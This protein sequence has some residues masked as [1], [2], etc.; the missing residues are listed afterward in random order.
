MLSSRSIFGLLL[1]CILI[2]LC[3]Y[4]LTLFKGDLYDIICKEFSQS[5]SDSG[6][7]RCSCPMSGDGE[8]SD[9]LIM[10]QVDVVRQRVNTAAEE[11]TKL[12]DRADKQDDL[13]SRMSQIEEKI[14]HFKRLVE[15]DVTAKETLITSLR[16]TQGRAVNTLCVV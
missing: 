2:G 12:K 16:D 3:T 15:R 10:K 4:Q 5:I 7:E 13:M 9:D 11:C 6:N 8:L 1:C 14:E